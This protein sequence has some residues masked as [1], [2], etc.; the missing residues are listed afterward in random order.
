MIGENARERRLVLRHQQGFDRAFRQFCK[1]A[2]RRSKHG[3]RAVTVQRVDQFSRCYGCNESRQV[4]I[5]GGNRDDRTGFGSGFFHH[6][7]SR[8]CFRLG[9]HFGFG[10]RS[11]RSGI[12]VCLVGS[13]FAGR[14]RQ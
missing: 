7:F 1:R 6:W 14:E 5:A 12:I 2:V 4:V 8:R 3:E 11:S 9:H 10:G 13:I